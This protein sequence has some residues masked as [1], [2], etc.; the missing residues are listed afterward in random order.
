ML[1]VMLLPLL[2]LLRL[3]RREMS[4]SLPSIQIPDLLECLTYYD[5]YV[6]TR[7][8]L[9]LRL[10]LNYYYYIVHVPVPGTGL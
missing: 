10:R 6:T 4:K 2:T 3:L 9:L 7:G 5:Y 1:M 8:L